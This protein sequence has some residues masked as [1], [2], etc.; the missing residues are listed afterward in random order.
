M[1]AYLDWPQQFSPIQVCE[2]GC[3]TQ[4]VD[5]AANSGR[6]Q[7]SGRCYKPSHMSGDWPASPLYCCCCSFLLSLEADNDLFGW[8]VLVAILLHL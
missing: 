8:V 2:D 6:W 7:T 5:E 4:E 1:I 3:P